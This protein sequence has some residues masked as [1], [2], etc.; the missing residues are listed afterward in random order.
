MNPKPFDS[1]L[2][3][4][5]AIWFPADDEDYFDFKLRIDGRWDED[6]FKRMIETAHN[7]LDE[8]D[9]VNLRDGHWDWTFGDGIDVIISF[10]T[11]PGFLAQN[12][13]GLSDPEY[14]QMMADRVAKLRELQKRY[15]EI[16]NPE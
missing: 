14:Q 2:A 8:A 6:Q 10:M 3:E 12:D 4:F 11:H 1:R 5:Q 15:S 9:A 13:L 7:L 16:R